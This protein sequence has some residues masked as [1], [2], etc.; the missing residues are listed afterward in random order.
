[1]YILQ[2]WSVSPAAKT[3]D[4]LPIQL[5]TPQAIVAAASGAGIHQLS[6]PAGGG[7]MDLVLD[8]AWLPGS[9]TCL[10]VTMPLAVLVFDLAVSARQPSVTVVVPS[11]DLIASSAVGAHMVAGQVSLSTCMLTLE[12]CSIPNF[13]IHVYTLSRYTLENA[14]GRT[15]ILIDLQ[16]HFALPCGARPR[17]AHLHAQFAQ[18]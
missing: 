10:A 1:V 11:S 7:Y 8:I 15:N 5:P 17:F 4:R 2:V 3:Q 13:K 12:T 14:N 16:C 9:D 18:S 6:A